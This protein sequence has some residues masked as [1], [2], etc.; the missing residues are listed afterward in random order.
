MDQQLYLVYEDPPRK[1]KV[2]AQA[3]R[4][5]TQQEAIIWL[6]QLISNQRGKRLKAGKNYTI[7]TIV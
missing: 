1:I 3:S 4:P 7:V 5:P 2:F 6:R